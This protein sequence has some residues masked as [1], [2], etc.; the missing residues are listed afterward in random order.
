MEKVC[1]GYIKT[2]P[3]RLW[4]AIT[5]P[6]LRAKYTVRREASSPTGR[7]GRASV[8]TAAEPGWQVSESKT[9]RSTARG[10]VDRLRANIFIAL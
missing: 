8:A 2:T 10:G 4:E 1:G 3:E 9:S 7:P 5:D 6:E